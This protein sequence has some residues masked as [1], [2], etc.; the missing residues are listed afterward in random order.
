MTSTVISTVLPLPFEPTRP[1]IG[2]F[3]SAKSDGSAVWHS[4]QARR[5]VLP[6]HSGQYAGPLTFSG[7]SNVGYVSRVLLVSFSRASSVSFLHSVL[8]RPR[9]WNH[10]REGSIRRKQNGQTVVVATMTP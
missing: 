8:P 10:R 5:F 1:I 7:G 9:H 2:L 3:E 6:P 4:G